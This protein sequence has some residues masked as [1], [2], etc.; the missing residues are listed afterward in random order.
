MGNNSGSGILNDLLNRTYYENFKEVDSWETEKA[1]LVAIQVS[2]QLADDKFKP[3]LITLATEDPNMKIRDTALK[4]LE[5]VYNVELV[6][7]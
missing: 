4:T 1:I 2:S 3:N 5:R 6:N 7:G